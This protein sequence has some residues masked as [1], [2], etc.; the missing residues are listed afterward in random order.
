MNISLVVANLARAVLLPPSCFFLLF[1][2]GWALAR[3]RPRL[4]RIVMGG[5]F[6][7]AF[8]LCTV[9]GSNLVVVPLE[10][11]TTPLDATHVA[12]TQAIVVLS[13]GSIRHAPEYG[14]AAIPDHVALARLRY[15]AKLQHETALPILVSGGIVTLDGSGPTLAAGLAAALREDFRTPVAWLEER[16]TNTAENAVESA[17]VLLGAG[18]KR[19][20]L[21]TDAMHMPRAERQFVRAGFEV[22]AAPTIFLG[23]GS[24]GFFD[25]LPS[26]EGLRRTHYAFY[27]WLGLFWY[28]IRH[29]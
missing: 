13:A 16:S 11:M 28:R 19:I 6:A 24:P 23:A 21:V 26:A 20:L 15:A 7:L 14:G 18:V 9:A 17:K 4:G 22:I 10:A 8:A 12:G 27:E 1:L 3:R 5:T 25:F 29:A 2:G